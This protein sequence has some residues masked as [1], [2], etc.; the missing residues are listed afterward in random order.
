MCWA[1]MRDGV[2]GIVHT[3]SVSW[4][5][6]IEVAGRPQ[7]KR[8]PETPRGSRNALHVTEVREHESSGLNVDWKA[9]PKEDR[10][11]T[12]ILQHHYVE[13]EGWFTSCCGPSGGANSTFVA[14][15]H[16]PKA[17]AARHPILSQ[18]LHQGHCEPQR[19]QD[20]WA[21]Q[22]PALLSLTS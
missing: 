6:D 10:Y 4:K 7:R 3:H 5:A 14:D 21:T 18:P 16:V 12:K 17:W 8:A 9:D 22:E 13:R 1:K 11:P 15:T 20:G 2:A 19:L